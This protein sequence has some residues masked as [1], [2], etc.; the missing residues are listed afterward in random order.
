MIHLNPV[1]KHILG[2][3][4]IPSLVTLYGLFCSKIKDSLLASTKL[5]THLNMLLSIELSSTFDYYVEQLIHIGSALSVWLG[6]IYLVIKM[7]KRDNKE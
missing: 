2:D 7:V 5:S 3:Y 4:I 1:T 6:C